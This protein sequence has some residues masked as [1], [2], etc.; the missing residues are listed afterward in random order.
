ME[1]PLS[2]FNLRDLVRE[3]CGRNLSTEG[4]KIE[5]QNRLMEARN[6]EADA[7]AQG[8]IR[9]GRA[10]ISK[11]GVSVQPDD[12][13]EIKS[14]NDNEYDVFSGKVRWRL[15]RVHR[16]FNNDGLEYYNPDVLHRID[17]SNTYSLNV[18][19]HWVRK[20]PYI[21]KIF[22]IFVSRTN[23]DEQ[24]LCYARSMARARKR[25]MTAEELQQPLITKEDVCRVMVN[26]M[27]EIEGNSMQNFVA[28]VAAKN[29]LNMAAFKEL[30]MVS[31][32][33]LPQIVND[34]CHLSKVFQSMFCAKSAQC[35][36]RMEYELFHQSTYMDQ[37]Q[38]LSQNFAQ[39]VDAQA[40]FRLYISSIPTVLVDM[41]KTEEHHDRPIC[42]GLLNNDRLN[43]YC[44]QV[45]NEVPP[46]SLEDCTA[47]GG[48]LQLIMFDALW[49]LAD[50]YEAEEIY[51]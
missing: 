18:G 24:R 37:L 7:Q 41:W 1:L 3:L 12:F 43:C 28:I 5:L 27:L 8:F 47:G 42:L 31:G 51:V 29:K 2:D 34:T 20:E 6:E 44:A 49:C 32:S 9:P 4:T 40:L 15:R 39:N 11:F 48:L 35:L 33:E 14:M 36:A 25:N 17:R 46:I 23:E 45:Q 21:H 30:F 26:I 38:R 10:P 50:G 16:A 13:A 19:E 22:V